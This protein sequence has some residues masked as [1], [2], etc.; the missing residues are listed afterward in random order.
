MSDII[1]LMVRHRGPLIQSTTEKCL[2]LVCLRGVSVCRYQDFCR[3]IKICR[4]IVS[5]EPF[6]LILM[7][8]VSPRTL[9]RGQH[10]TYRRSVAY[11]LNSHAEI[12]LCL[13]YKL[14]LGGKKYAKRVKNNKNWY[15]EPQQ[16]R[17]HGGSSIESHVLLS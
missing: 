14:R 7:P 13:Y 4:H 17:R 2:Q 9:G 5:Y 12:Y 6:D 15:I 16:C 1:M 8:T 10:K 3:G 11:T